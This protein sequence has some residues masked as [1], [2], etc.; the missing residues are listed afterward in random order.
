[1]IYPS[2][3]IFDSQPLSSHTKLAQRSKRDLRYGM[4]QRFEGHFAGSN[5]NELFFQTWNPT[6]A[7]R[8][9]IVITHGLAEHSECYHA[10][11][12]ILCE[13]G[14]QVFAWDLRGHGR[15]EGKRGFVLN[16]SSYIDDLGFFLTQVRQH[17]KGSMQNLILFGHSMGG[18][19]T[20]RHL[21]TR[22]VQYGALVLSSPAL[23]LS[24]PVPKFKETLANVAVKWL[25]SLTMFNE[26]KYADLT[27]DEEMLKSYEKD[28]L[29]HDKISPGLFLS[30]VDNFK[31]AVE[32]AEA[33]KNPVLMQLA[34]E[35]RLVSSA[36]ARELFEHLPNKKNHLI[37]YPESYH[38]VYNDL[39]RDKVIAD[40]KKFISPYLT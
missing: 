3:K 30:M 10:L 22:D 21:Q 28:T 29:R 34:G 5:Q 6:G 26:I 25:P 2:P 31:L 18:L 37:I 12:K 8:G 38:E 20:L 7:V 13:D 19:I 36:A 15:S 40:L 35:D 14:W 11:A 16:I 33:I 39:D 23:G 4:A 24:M 9:G 1:M 32:S 17:F 27:H